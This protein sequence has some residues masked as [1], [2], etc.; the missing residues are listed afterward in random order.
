MLTNRRQCSKTDKKGINSDY[1]GTETGDNREKDGKENI[2]FSVC[3]CL[4]VMNK[5]L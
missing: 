5:R 2:I 1:K 3:S 4:L